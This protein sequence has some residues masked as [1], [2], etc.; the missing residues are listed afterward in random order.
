MRTLTQP[1]ITIKFPTKYQKYPKKEKKRTQK[2]TK[3]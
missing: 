3:E 2:K 1:N